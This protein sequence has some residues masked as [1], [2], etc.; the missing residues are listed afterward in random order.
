MA[1]DRT[2]ATSLRDHW[3]L[4]LAEGIILL[5][6]GLAA[7]LLP[8]I[9][10]IL[11]IFLGW[12]LVA[13]AL[14]GLLTTVGMY[15]APGFWPSLVSIAAALGA[16]LLLLDWP[17]H[18]GLPLRRVLVG[19]FEIEGVACLLFAIEHKRAMS[20]RWAWMLACGLVDLAIGGVIVAGYAGSAEW[21]IG[22][23]VGVSMT[24]GGISLIAMALDARA[25]ASAEDAERA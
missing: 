10:L 23:L 1:L 3:G 8:G 9:A 22:L 6:L 24:F 17:V 11:A 20:G 19:F 14:A 2:V 25:L 16:G 15:R 4:Y 21:T 5:V 12:L 13:T 18:A 7:L